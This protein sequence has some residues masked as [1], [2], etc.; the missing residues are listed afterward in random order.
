I[1]RHGG[2]IFI[3]PNTGEVSG[4][5][6]D[7]SFGQGRQAASQAVP[8]TMAY[9]RGLPALVDQDTAERILR[10]DPT[11]L[12]E[13]LAAF[14]TDS[15]PLNDDEIAE[16]VRRFDGVRQYLRDLQKRGALVGQNGTTWND[17]TYQQA[18]A[19]PMNNY[20]GYQATFLQNAV[21]QSANDPTVVV[22]GAPPPPPPAPAPP[23]VPVG[24]TLAQALQG[25]PAQPQN[26]PPIT[27]NQ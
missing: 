6:D 12:P 10:L 26:V 14:D 18:M 1:D 20:L 17:A 22:V 2:N 3:D 8:L 5:D 4:I 15:K 7:K 24:L 21:Q 25:Q 16:A 19:D 23:P 27:I 11:Q 13:M 9:Y